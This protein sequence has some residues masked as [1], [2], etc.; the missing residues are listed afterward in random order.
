MIY[1]VKDVSG[2]LTKYLKEN[3]WVLVDF[4]ATWC[5]PCTQQEPVLKDVSKQ[6]QEVK[7]VKL[8]VDKDQATADE[9]K[10][11]SIPTLILFHNRE[12]NWRKEGFHSLRELKIN[13]EEILRTN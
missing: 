1:M 5:G 4:S 2:Q 3:E 12:K 7:F 10:V 9:Y 6:I 11:T 8:D 13:I